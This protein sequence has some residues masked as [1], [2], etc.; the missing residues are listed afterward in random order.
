[1]IELIAA[2]DPRLTRE[3]VDS[4]LLP[5]AC[6]LRDDPSRPTG[7]F[8]R[9]RPCRPSRYR[10]ERIDVRGGTFPAPGGGISRRLNLYLVGATWGRC[11]AATVIESESKPCTSQTGGGPFSSSV[12]VR[13]TTKLPSNEYLWTKDS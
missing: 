6:R 12:T 2:A 4:T 3:G 1:M 8:R 5:L 13:L 7:D 11:M 9:T 10:L